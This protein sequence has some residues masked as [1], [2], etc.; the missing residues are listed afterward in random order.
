MLAS[1]S[2]SPSAVKIASDQASS[3]APR[4]VWF[5]AVASG[6]GPGGP[7]GVRVGDGA[8]EGSGV[9]CTGD[10]L[11]VGEPVGVTVA[12][13][14][15]VRLAGRDRA[16]GDG[17]PFPSFASLM[18]AEPSADASGVFGAGGAVGLPPRLIVR[19]TPAVKQKTRTPIHTSRNCGG[20][21]AA[22]L[23]LG[24]LSSSPNRLPG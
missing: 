1:V 24:K 4:G 3:L 10:R 17:K 15:G 8:A 6:A 19:A 5:S 14:V 2:G 11:G 21:I 20:R 18:V 12:D 7:V 13:G 9:V 23:P 22:C 16:T